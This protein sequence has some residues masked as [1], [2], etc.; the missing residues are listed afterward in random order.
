MQFVA[1]DL[2]TNEFDPLSSVAASQSDT[3][4]EV[5]IAV[6][7]PPQFRDPTPPYQ[8]LLNSGN[9]TFF[10]TKADCQ[11]FC[12]VKSHGVCKDPDLN[13]SLGQSIE[14]TVEAVNGVISTNVDILF[15]EDGR[16]FPAPSP[17]RVR[18]GPLMP[19]TQFVT[20]PLAGL[21]AVTR[22]NPSFRVWAFTPNAIDA[23]VYIIVKQVKFGIRLFC[24]LLIFWR[25]ITGLCLEENVPV[26]LPGLHAWN[27]AGYVDDDRS[28][29]CQYSRLIHKPCSGSAFSGK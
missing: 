5:S 12:V 15:L 9:Q 17:S 8:C 21:Q 3:T 14:F 22:F 29:V 26:L 11:A 20:D 2:P 18:I 28:Q 1:S 4:L 27:S 19:T 13:V 7:M 24:D 10:S 23:K 6:E 25:L 16:D